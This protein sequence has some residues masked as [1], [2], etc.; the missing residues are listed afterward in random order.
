M[1]TCSSAVR[2]NARSRAWKT[3]WVVA[4][5][6]TIAPGSW[7]DEKNPSSAWPAFRGTGTSTTTAADLPTEWSRETVAWRT[8]LE[9]YGQ[10]SPVLWGERVFVTSVLGENKDRLL[11]TAVERA[12]GKVLWSREWS[13]T[14]KI[15]DSDYTSKAAPTPAVDA[16]RVYALF[17]SGDLVAMTHDG[18]ELWK[19][20]LAGEYGEYKGNHGLGSSP[21]LAEG[22]VIVL[23][24]HD[25]PSYLAALDRATG[26]TIWKTDRP[27]RTSW[28]SPT[29]RPVPGGA[30]ILVSSSGVVEAYDAKTGARLWSFE[31]LDK[32]NVPSPSVIESADGAL[33]VIGSTEV[34]SNVAIRLGGS[35]DVT[36]SHLAWRAADA[37]SSFGSPL[38]HEGRIYFV[39]K[40]GVA[41]CLE[42]QGGAT[43]WNARIGGSCWAS[44]IGAPG[45][46]YF[47]TKDGTTHV[48]RTSDKHEPIADNELPTDDRVYG[49]A[50]GARAFF[51]RTGRQLLAVGQP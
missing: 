14:Q 24:D 21:A 9:G 27:S 32:N 29:V 25:G 2:N 22:S 37:T 51:I 35:G 5:A 19:R 43:L 10:S 46:I 41:F 7:A 48:A 38:V 6:A 18:E 42:A 20:S 39:N 3:I 16:E 30:E 1:S 31:G 44:P 47:F 40:S 23:V 50:A 34:G 8:E 45:R 28:S 17:E 33:V 36:G 4:I 13:G 15:A 26:K 49:V 11:V 12:T